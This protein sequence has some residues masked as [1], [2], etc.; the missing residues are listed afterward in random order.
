[1]QQTGLNLGKARQELRKGSPHNFKFFF[2]TA[3]FSKL[4]TS[5]KNRQ[6]AAWEYA[7][8]RLVEKHHV[9]MEKRGV[10]LESILANR[11]AGLVRD[12]QYGNACFPYFDFGG[13]AG[14][15]KE[16]KIS[17]ITRKEVV[18]DYGEANS[19]SVTNRAV[20]CE[21]PIDAL[22]YAPATQ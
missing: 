18:K 14:V 3:R 8:T 20:I 2:H 5:T 6:R 11:F 4:R 13:V 9:Y 10:F 21:A 1:M 17:N 16:M 19:W 22:S 12:D 7:D 15:K